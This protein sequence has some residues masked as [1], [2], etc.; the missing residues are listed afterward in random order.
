VANPVRPATASACHR[1]RLGR[2]H[3]TQKKTVKPVQHNPP[4]KPARSWIE[5]NHSSRPKTR[6]VAA[7]RSSRT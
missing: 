5:M 3:Q 4:P 1:L 6:A 2:P 7:S